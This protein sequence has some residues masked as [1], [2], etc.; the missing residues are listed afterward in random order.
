MP[1]CGRT[2]WNA[3]TN[4]SASA[5]VWTITDTMI[6]I[7]ILYG[8]G[9]DYTLFHVTVPLEQIFRSRKQCRTKCTALSGSRIQFEAFIDKLVVM[10]NISGFSDFSPK[11]L[12]R[13]LQN[14]LGIAD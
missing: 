8:K 3:G 7:P 11:H 4:A 1:I 10:E 13:T 14:G 2:R 12:D 6:K 9:K 5:R